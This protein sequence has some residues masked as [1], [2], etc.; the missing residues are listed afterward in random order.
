[1]V[2]LVICHFTANH[3]KRTFCSVVDCSDTFQEFT[4]LWGH[5]TFQSE[6]KTLICSQDLWCLLMAISVKGLFSTFS[7]GFWNEVWL[8]DILHIVQRGRTRGGKGGN[9][10][11]G[12]TTNMKWRNPW[13]NK[14]SSNCWIVR[15]V[16]SRHSSRDDLMFHRLQV[17]IR[18][19]DASLPNSLRWTFLMITHPW[20]LDPIPTCSDIM[21]LSPGQKILS[22]LSLSN[23][24]N[25][26]IVGLTCERRIR[27]L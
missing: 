19:W 22:V 9:G 6:G 11:R 15:T 27:T 21:H 5:H 12:A 25:G 1:M 20:T 24:C 10:V 8:R 2:S 4:V 17:K 18:A 7:C 26:L 13:I 16:L 23:N 14:F 3:N